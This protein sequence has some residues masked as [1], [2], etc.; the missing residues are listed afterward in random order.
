M[1]IKM[2]RYYSLSLIVILNHK[3]IFVITIYLSLP[4]IVLPAGGD[5]SFKRILENKKVLISSLPENFDL[6]FHL[7]HKNQKNNVSSLF[8]TISTFSGLP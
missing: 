7:K 3:A 8:R 6:K 2:S 4:N 5:A 1:V